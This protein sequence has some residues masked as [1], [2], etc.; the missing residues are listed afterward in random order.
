MSRFPLWGVGEVIYSVVL[1]AED[2]FSQLATALSAQIPEDHS[3]LGT[4]ALQRDV[5]VA[6]VQVAMEFLQVLLVF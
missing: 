2:L 6:E 5:G 1:S 3:N 4:S